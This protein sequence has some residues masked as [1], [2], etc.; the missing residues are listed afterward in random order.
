MGSLLVCHPPSEGAGPRP[1]RQRA[2]VSEG[3]SGPRCCLPLL[4]GGEPPRYTWISDSLWGVLGTSAYSVP[5]HS[6]WG[7]LPNSN[8]LTAYVAVRRR[9]RG[10]QRSAIS[11]N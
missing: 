6:P 4:K 7:C 9:R 1:G 5:L 11:V 10:G 8:V 2:G 3:D